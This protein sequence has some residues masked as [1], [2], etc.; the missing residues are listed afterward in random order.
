MNPNDPTSHLPKSATAKNRRN[1]S[2]IEWEAHAREER[3]LSKALS[4]SRTR[5]REREKSWIHF[6]LWPFFSLFLED[7]R[8]LRSTLESARGIFAYSGHKSFCPSP[9]LSLSH[10]PQLARRRL[11]PRGSV[12][13]YDPSRDFSSSRARERENARGR[14]RGVR[15]LKNEMNL[16]FLFSSF[17]RPRGAR[18]TFS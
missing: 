14:V 8:D 2:R 11:Y 17:S 13:I 3:K 16:L 12:Q 15:Q 10:L 4:R 18:A 9:L 7:E 5:A 6:S 1:T